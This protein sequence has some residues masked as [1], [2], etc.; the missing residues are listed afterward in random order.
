MDRSHQE[1]SSTIIQ[2]CR[3]VEAKGFVAA[4][5]GNISTRLENGNILATP[6]SLNKGLVQIDDLVEVTLE[7]KQAG[8]KRN[9]STEMQMHYFIYTHRLDVNAVVHCHPVYATG[10]AAA[11][12]ALAQNIFPEVIVQFGKIPLA[13]YA[14]PSTKEVGESLRPYIKDHDAILLSN[15]GVVTYG[16]DLWDAYY[17][18]EK[19]EQI[20]HMLFVAQTLGGAKQ[21]NEKQVAALHELSKTVY[22]N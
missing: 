18:M 22:K 20:A 6:T 3:K 21:L 12:K 10:F 8:G 16:K 14:T 1:I 7:G 4:T 15:H 9:P 13:D 11:G 5:D 19:V 17:K 2:V